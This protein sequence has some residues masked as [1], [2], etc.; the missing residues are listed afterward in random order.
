M[1]WV[2]IPQ[3]PGQPQGARPSG[4]PPYGYQ[5]QQTSGYAGTPQ[6][7]YASQPPNGYPS[8]NGYDGSYPGG[9][10]SGK[11]LGTTSVVIAIT[12]TVLLPFI[13]YLTNRMLI[14]SGT[15]SAEFG[16]ILLA[17]NILS[18]VIA[19]GGLALGIIAANRST[20]AL[21]G[22]GAGANGVIILSTLVSYLA[23]YTVYAI[24]Y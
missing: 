17:I 5:G 21:G 13:S 24:P 4:Y 14:T 16:W 22:F 9:H 6:S 15:S 8:Y 12:L 18:V 3:Q 23:Q 7:G 19:G 1:C 11:G 2:T 20:R 10:G